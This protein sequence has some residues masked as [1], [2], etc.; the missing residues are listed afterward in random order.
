MRF[1]LQG[2]WNNLERYIQTHSN[3]QLSHGICPDCMD[4]HYPEVAE[5]D[6]EEES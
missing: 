6:P 5:E 1:S 2:Y 3:A 4:E